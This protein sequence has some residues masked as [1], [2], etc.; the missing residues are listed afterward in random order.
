LGFSTQSTLAPRRFRFRLVKSPRPANGP[1][2]PRINLGPPGDL[3]AGRANEVRK[4][5]AHAYRGYQAR[6]LP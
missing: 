1:R 6:A 3:W 2:P 4:A 5:F